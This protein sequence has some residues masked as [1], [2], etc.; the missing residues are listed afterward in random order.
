M[1]VSGLVVTEPPDQVSVAFD[2]LATAFSV[3]DA[4]EQM[5]AVPFVLPLTVTV[6]CCFT[7]T[8]AVAVA[9]QPLAVAVT[10]YWV[11]PGVEVG[12]FTVALAPRLWLQL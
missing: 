9:V 1:T 4:P 2:G 12:T 3:V 8:V 10:V 6:G 7:V 11:V 5:E